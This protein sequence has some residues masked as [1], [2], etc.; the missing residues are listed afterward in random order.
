DVVVEADEDE[1]EKEKDVDVVVEADEDEV[2]KEKDVDVVVEA[3]EDE[4]EKEKDVDVVVEADEDEVEKE[5][6]VDAVV[7]AD[8]DE[9]E[10]EKDVETET[11]KDKDY[12]VEIE[13]DKDEDVVTEVT[14][15]IVIAGYNARKAEASEVAR[16]F[17]K[18]DQAIPGILE[19]YWVAAFKQNDIPK[20]KA[21]FQNTREYFK[22][23]W[24]RW[25]TGK[26]TRLGR[27]FRTLF[28]NNFRETKLF[29]ER[30]QILKELEASGTYTARES[31]LIAR[32][33]AEDEFW[34]LEEKDRKELRKDVRQTYQNQEG[35]DKGLFRFNRKVELT[36]KRA[37]NDE[38]IKRLT[39][40]KLEEMKTNNEVGELSIKENNDKE[41]LGRF[42]Q[43]R[44][45][46][47]DFVHESAGENLQTVEEL[48]GDRAPQ[49]KKD[50]GNLVEMYAVDDTITKEQLGNKLGVVIATHLPPEEGD[51]F[52]NKL[53]SAEYYASTL[54]DLGDYYRGNRQNYEGQ[55]RIAADIESKEIR[56]GFGVPGERT[57]A[58]LLRGEKLL[59]KL[60]NLGINPATATAAAGMA[61]FALDVFAGPV[62]SSMY[63]K[64]IRS[65]GIS[66]VALIPIAPVIGAPTIVPLLVGAGVAGGFSFLKERSKMKGKTRAELRRREAGGEAL[67]GPGKRRG[68]WE[69]LR[70]RKSEIDFLNQVSEDVPRVS[71]RNLL[72]EISALYDN[73]GTSEQS[74]KPNTA[75]DPL[76]AIGILTKAKA[77]VEVSDG[78]KQLVSSK[79]NPEGMGLISY[80]SKENISKERAQID[81]AIAHLRRDLGNQVGSEASSVLHN[82]TFSEYTEALTSLRVKAI[83]DTKPATSLPFAEKLIAR[84]PERF[85]KKVIGTLSDN[86]EILKNS[87][88]EDEYI[89][90]DTSLHQARRAINKAINIRSTGKAASSAIT[91]A[92]VGEAILEAG[93]AERTSEMIDSGDFSGPLTPYQWILSKTHG[94]NE[95]QVDAFAPPSI[96]N[97]FTITTDSG[98]REIRPPE[99]FSI[100]DDGDGHLDLLDKDGEIFLDNF[101]D[102]ETG[103][104]ATWTTEFAK[105]NLTIHGDTLDITDG[106]PQ[107]ITLE[108]GTEMT[109]PGEN[110]EYIPDENQIV[111]HV[112][113]E[114]QHFET[115]IELTL[116]GGGQFTQESVDTLENLG[117]DVTK[118]DIPTTLADLDQGISQFELPDG[119]VVTM[120]AYVPEGTQIIADPDIEGA[121][122]LISTEDNSVLVNNM[123]FRDNGDLVRSPRVMEQLAENNISIKTDV[124]DTINGTTLTEGEAIPAGFRDIRAGDLDPEGPDGGGGWWN[125]YRNTIYAETGQYPSNGETNA[126]KNLLRAY[127]QNHDGFEYSIRPEDGIP[128]GIVRNVHFTET[129]DGNLSAVSAPQS[130]NM[131]YEEVP[132]VLTAERPDAL[133]RLSQ[134]VSVAREKMESG[135]GLSEL[136]QLAYNIGHVGGEHQIAE[137]SREDIDRLLEYMGG[138]DSPDVETSFSFTPHEVIFSTTEQSLEGS[139]DTFS[140]MDLSWNPPTP[141]D[142]PDIYPLAV[143]PPEVEF[144]TQGPAQIPN[145]TSNDDEESEKDKDKEVELEI[146]KEKDVE[147]EK[148]KDK[149]KEVELETNSSAVNASPAPVNIPMPS[150][151][152]EDEEDDSIGDALEDLEG[153]ESKEN[154]VKNEDESE[155]EQGVDE[156]FDDFLES[157]VQNRSK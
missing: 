53:S 76:A 95:A 58:E 33:R 25:S 105:N 42:A 150:T 67:D 145:Y 109:L 5:K 64:A 133:L 32:Q 28:F 44:E 73:P 2:E 127:E 46:W 116:T 12:D 9:V 146:E 110:W 82:M 37:A 24:D 13:K 103:D 90:D 10:K 134:L 78:Q 136:E 50:I 8:K 126:I 3:D 104:V 135:E 124:L 55:G 144:D 151:T 100:V 98:V 16:E 47:E 117:F 71:S 61:T 68:L 74:L 112:E 48:L 80:S 27:G 108:N 113:P 57:D 111:I 94:V 38:A 152:D 60:E 155:T 115:D 69:K 72:E 79:G 87:L 81:L 96:E 18:N 137:L 54:A 7:E 138:G 99:G 120:N 31:L 140:H 11:E 4:V 75:D 17:V 143:L 88:D 128:E 101:A 40:K 36:F 91:A 51:G 125:Y 1:V 35:W 49:F 92:L 6:D 77:Y 141:G 15:N 62:S 154:L 56:L 114:N 21:F 70:I 97:A 132:V 107:L 22:D 121:Y 52:A 102:S 23:S 131:W 149:E 26:E 30:N 41:M 65:A 14:D 129:F 118:T 156:A 89:I 20:M 84:W 142:F 29:R 130:I 119:Q 106:D 147:I 139:G 157:L 85:G 45:M 153:G 66:A 39:L 43:D 123:T 34:G 63:R 83:E 122:D 148:D 59:G 86:E 93:H 19:G